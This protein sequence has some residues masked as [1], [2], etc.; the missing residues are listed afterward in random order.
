MNSIKINSTFC[1]YFVRLSHKTLAENL[2]PRLS[3][4]HTSVLV[5]HVRLSLDH[6]SL[7]FFKNSLFPR[8]FPCVATAHTRNSRPKLTCRSQ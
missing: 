6:I 4:V 1:P 7:Y 2:G 5:F 3:I 8:G